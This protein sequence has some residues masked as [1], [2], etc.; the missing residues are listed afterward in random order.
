MKN[1][2]I[3]GVA[4]V[5]VA[6]SAPMPRAQSLGDVARREEARRKNVK[7]GK[8][9]TNESLRGD[10]STTPSAATPAPAVAPT[11]VPEKKDD[12]DPKKDQ[13]YWK[14]RMGQARDNLQRAKMFEEALQSRINALSADFS[15][16]DDPAQRGQIADNRQ[17]ALAELDR[18]KKDIAAYEK[19]VRDIEDEARKA[20]VPPG[21]V[22]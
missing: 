12:Q 19:Q 18:V 4:A 14:D 21:W 20:G 16:R 6:M 1:A 10:A 13:K 5:F 9:Y 15:A 22:R 3:L 8:T 2:I 11:P 17:K 7:S